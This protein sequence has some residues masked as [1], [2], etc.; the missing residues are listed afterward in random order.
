MRGRTTIEEHPKTGRKSIVAT[1]IPYQ[2]NKAKLIEK[3]AEL[4]RDKT[5]R[6]H[7]R[8]A[9][10]VRP[11]RHAHRHR[12]EEGRRSR[13]RPEQPL[14]DDAAAGVVRHQHAGDRRGAPADPVAE[15]G[16]HALH[17][18]PPRRGHAPD[19]VRSARGARSDAHPRGVEDRRR[20][21]RRGHRSHPLVEGHRHRQDGPDAELRP[22]GPPGAGDP[23]HAAR[24][25]D[26]PGTRRADR[27]DQ[28]GR[29]A[30]RAAGGD[31]GHR[32]EPD[33]GRDRASWRR[34][35]RSTATRAA[36]RCWTSTSARS[37]SRT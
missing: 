29:R 5:D 13:D 7:R 1:E 27:R 19:A 31:P 30:D 18:P 8:H 15:A 11:R 26:R 9:R 4:V 32:A 17:R 21:H 14:E 2:V 37:T 24:Q 34:S 16:A 10:R 33:G 6:R 12:P 23:G 3:I 35:R 36:P 22:V 25:A 28:G 20:Q